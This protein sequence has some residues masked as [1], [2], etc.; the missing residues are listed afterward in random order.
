[1]EASDLPE[2]TIVE[3]IRN[4]K[5][6]RFCQVVNSKF[7][8]IEVRVGDEWFEEDGRN[9]HESINTAPDR[10]DYVIHGVREDW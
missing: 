6:F 8:D 9:S 7:V 10:Y 2:G 4:G 3:H 1:M 5:S